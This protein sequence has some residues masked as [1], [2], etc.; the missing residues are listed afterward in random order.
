MKTI[1]IIV[2]F[3]LISLQPLL[4]AE[5]DIAAETDFETRNIPSI[6]YQ[7]QKLLYLFLIKDYP[8]LLEFASD[9]A[10]TQDERDFAQFLL[11]LPALSESKKNSSPG[12]FQLDDSALLK[13]Q[14][15]AYGNLKYEEA[16]ILNRMSPSSGDTLYREGMSLLGMGKLEDAGRSLEQVLPDDP[17]FPYARIAII[18]KEVMRQ[19]IDGAEKDVR[20]LISH[21]SVS[22]SNLSDKVRLLLGQ[23]LFEKGLYSEALQEFTSIPQNSHF[24]EDALLGQAWCYAKLEDYVKAVSLFEKTKMD[25]LDPSS[26]EALITLGHSLIRSGSVTQARQH[27]DQALAVGASYEKE[28]SQLVDNKWQR[29]KYISLLKGDVEPVT[30]Q[31]QRYLS[32]LNRK[33]S[34]DSLL[35]E[36]R[37]LETIKAGFL[38]IKHTIKN[39]ETRFDNI[40]N[41]LNEM[42]VRI[43]SE[44][45]DLKDSLIK[46]DIPLDP[47]M[48]KMANKRKKINDQAPINNNISNMLS[49]WKYSVEREIRSE[50]QIVAGEILKELARDK[51]LRCFDEPVICHIASYLAYNKGSFD[52]SQIRRLVLLLDSMIGDMIK[53]KNGGNIYFEELLP[54]VRGNINSKTTTINKTIDTIKKLKEATDFNINEVE[55]VLKT[56]HGILDL[57]ILQSF[58]N[59]RYDMEDFKSKVVAGIN[60]IENSSTDDSKVQT[61]K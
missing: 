36:I 5:T 8:S 23:I 56:A 22:K 14:V 33:P 7:S 50:T 31:E 28:L 12:K 24:Y 47:D 10:N 17:L 26:R 59:A 29:G 1:W 49:A 15:I 45:A 2:S 30:E 57:Y 51:Q 18:Q 42:A 55:K 46:A 60:S 61:G 21:P 41:G 25:I 37:Y 20:Y 11:Q 43:E 54:G 27:F 40:S 4:A 16:L 13:L 19:N 52:K 48:A 34:L 38:K 39:S 6:K 35:S 32:Y 58:V 9:S 44:V 3:L 53:A